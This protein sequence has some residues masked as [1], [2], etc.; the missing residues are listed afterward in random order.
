MI[1]LIDQY[2]QQ[3]ESLYGLIATNSTQISTSIR[4]A[5]KT[6]IIESAGIAA[7]SVTKAEQLQQ[8]INELRLLLLSTC[9]HMHE[10]PH[11]AAKLSAGEKKK[12]KRFSTVKKKKS[13]AK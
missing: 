5:N 4:Q 6:E 8:H 9:S 12:T 13:K 2:E 3:L 1:N 11:D 10:H 7:K